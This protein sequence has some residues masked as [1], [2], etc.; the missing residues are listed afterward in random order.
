MPHDPHLHSDSLATNT[1]PVLIVEDES[2]IAMWLE[3]LLEEFGFAS[4]SC[5]SAGEAIAALDR[6]DFQFAL[7][8]VNLGAGMSY[9]IADAL[10]ARRIPFA[11][12]TGY[13]N[14]GVESAYAEVPVLHK[15]FEQRQLSAVIG[16]LLTANT[17]PT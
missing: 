17:R 10:K 2:L 14:V 8:D 6:T 1:A 3:D 11:F 9:S 4:Q 16:R 13:G 12:A 5:A 15:P 7:L